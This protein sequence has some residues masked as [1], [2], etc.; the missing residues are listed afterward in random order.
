M[1]TDPVMPVVQMSYSPL[2]KV[3]FL[4]TFCL[5]QFLD[6]FNT[7]ALF[8]AIP[9]I[10]KALK[11]TSAETVWIISA[12]QLTFAAFLLVVRPLVLL[13]RSLAEITPRLLN[14]MDASAMCITRVRRVSSNS[15]LRSLTNV[16]LTRRTCLHIRYL[17]A[18]CL[19]PCLRFCT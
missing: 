9:A 8:P 12:T 13:K 14:R 7:S 2:R 18:R 6:A 4:V 10:G 11:M 19:C 17:W 1:I 3:A 5:A 16:G 15:G